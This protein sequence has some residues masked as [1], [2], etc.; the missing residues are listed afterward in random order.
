MGRMSSQSDQMG[1]ADVQVEGCLQGDMR[2]LAELRQEYQPRLERI[3]RARGA[4]PTEAEDVLADLWADCV[5][6]GDE[7]PSL[8]E[9]FKGKC[10]LAGWLG[11]VATNRWIDL[12]RRQERRG[13][14]RPISHPGH[15]ADPLEGIAASSIPTTEDSLMELLRDSLQHAFARCPAR[16]MVLLR[17]VHLHGLTQRQVGGMMRWTEWKVSRFLSQAMAQIEKDTLRAVRQHDPWLELTWQD[18]VDLCQTY[19]LGFV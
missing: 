18:F 9:K 19:K 5:P 13:E 14:V 2:A 10:T 7:R 4:S 16:A 15:E 1:Q 3:L 8:L 12:K 6:G 11:T 17:L